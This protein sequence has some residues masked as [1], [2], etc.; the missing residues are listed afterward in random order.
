MNTD[1]QIENNKETEIDENTLRHEFSRIK[2]LEGAIR[3]YYNKKIGS[4]LILCE[5]EKI[6][7]F[8]RILN[9]TLS[10]IDNIPNDNDI[11]KYTHTDLINT[12]FLLTTLSEEIA[13]ILKEIDLYLMRFNQRLAIASDEWSKH[14][15]FLLTKIRELYSLIDSIY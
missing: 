10:I 1:N 13:P 11:Y 7:E 5:Y 6:S 14:D 8:L 15:D 2:Y 12:Y 9:K 3:S 4:V